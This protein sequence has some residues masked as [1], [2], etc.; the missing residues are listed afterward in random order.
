M[1]KKKKIK[2][3]D[4]ISHCNRK[5]AFPPSIQKGTPGDDGVRGPDGKKGDVGH[6][7]VVGPRGSPGQDGSPG[8]PG[9]P[10]YPGKPV[11]PLAVH[12]SKYQFASDLQCCV[13]MQDWHAMQGASLIHRDHDPDQD[14]VMNEDE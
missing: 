1:N 9:L 8:H 5:K 7:G 11:S 4:C 14:K 2:S 10:G 12:L 3:T 13:D 6:I